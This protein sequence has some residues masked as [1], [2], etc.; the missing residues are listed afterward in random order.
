[1]NLKR[2]YEYALKREHEGRDF[3]ERNAQRVAHEA[4]AGIFA[5]CRPKRKSILRLSKACLKVSGAKV[6]FPRCAMGSRKKVFSRIGLI[7]RC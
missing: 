2:I 1:M 4:A 5:S 7:W 6:L 3:F